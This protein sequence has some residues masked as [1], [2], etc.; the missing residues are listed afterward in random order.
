MRGFVIVVVVWS[1]FVFQFIAVA[2][3][4]ARIAPPLVRGWL[5]G[6]SP[7]CSW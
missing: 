3:V 1:Y 7:V 2:L 4:D 6:L 5:F